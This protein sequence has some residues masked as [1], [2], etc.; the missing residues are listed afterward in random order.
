MTTIQEQIMT[1]LYGVWRKRWWAVLVAWLVC[2]MGWAF[3]ATIPNSF[4]SSARILVE[5]GSLLQSEMGLRDSGRELEVVR[6][7]LTSRLNLEKV[8]R[9]TELDAELE[10]DAQID[11]AISTISDGISVSS[12]SG[13]LFTISYES[14]NP[15]LTD[16]ENADL[17]RDIVDNLL[18]IFME[19]NVTSNRDDINEAVRF[20]EDQ[21][22][23]RERELEAAEQRRAE[24]EERYLGRLAGEGN[25]NDNVR[26]A[27]NQLNDVQLQLE[28]AT[29]SLYA[30]QSQLG[31]VPQALDQGSMDPIQSPAR[32]RVNQMEQTLSDL[33]A[34]G[35][36][37]SHPDVIL[38][39][40][41]LERLRE[42]AEAEEAEMRADGVGVRAPTSNPVYVNL[43]SRVFDAQSQVAALR[44]RRDRLQQ[45]IADMER[46][47]QEQPGIAAEQAK[48]NRDYGV[49][50]SQYDALLRSREEIRLQSDVQTQTQ[51]VRFSVV[52]PPSQPREPSAP[53][54]PLYLS[55]VLIAAFGAG[56][57]I[58][59]L[60]SQLRG[61]F[62]T[63]G[64]LEARY[65]T[66][67]LGAVSEIVTDEDR[68]MNRIRLAI[69]LVMTFGLV[70]IWGALV[71]YEM[72]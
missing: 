65:D 54:R 14:S 21:L 37:D 42:Q 66:P 6:Q 52:D 20:F 36:L 8:L 4:R 46:R 59:F 38:A 34:A 43:R 71:L 50:R 9:R 70:A 5:T 51:Q 64:Q 12:Q 27:R 47:Q 17:A 44:A 69:L 15:E 63:A 67:V 68:Q 10:N 18:Q 49:L 24:F 23:Q 2:L 58:S 60:M 1:T 33:Y 22:A 7:T 30:L 3:V 32:Q 72:V 26:A 48:L 62:I 53:N 57:G 61:G 55:V 40:R 35:K 56:L 25:I 19:E 16:Q 13:N 39:K 41:Q 11:A 29:R 31:S 28:Q 45:D